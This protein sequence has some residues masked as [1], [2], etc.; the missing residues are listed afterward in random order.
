MKK[1]SLLTDLFL[2]PENVLEAKAL[3]VG[4]FVFPSKSKWSKSN[5]KRKDLLPLIS[6]SLIKKITHNKK[7]KY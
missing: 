3:F 7:S 5:T 4:Y 1:G 6:F 2:P